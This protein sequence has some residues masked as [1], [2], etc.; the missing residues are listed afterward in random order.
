M[1]F[2]ILLT[3]LFI[4]GGFYGINRTINAFKFNINKQIEIISNLS[5]DIKSQET[6]IDNLR[7]LKDRQIDSNFI[8]NSLQS[9]NDF[10][11]LPTG[12]IFKGCTIL[13]FGGLIYLFFNKYDPAD[14]FGDMGNL[15]LEK[16]I[17]PLNAKLFGNFFVSFDQSFLG[18]MPREGGADVIVEI[19]KNVATAIV[20]MR[21][22]EN[23]LDKTWV[24]FSPEDI[25]ALKHEAVNLLL[26][27]DSWAKQLDFALLELNRLQFS[28][29][30]AQQCLVE[31]QRQLYLLENKTSALVPDLI[32]EAASG[33]SSWEGISIL[34]IADI[35]GSFPT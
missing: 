33:L 19:S 17:V 14:C 4:S 28:L 13:I 3:I 35:V 5:E 32:L 22:K 29:T 11:D 26:Q 8:T 27:N 9:L 7:D 23:I 18:L 2:Q 6:I 30:R 24:P 31:T 15:I 16:V 12:I 1:I 10:S 34:D 25:M 20:T 21:Y